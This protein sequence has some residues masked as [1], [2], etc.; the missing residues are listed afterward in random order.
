MNVGDVLYLQDKRTPERF[1]ILEILSMTDVDFVYDI[2]VRRSS[3]LDDVEFDCGSTSV[4]R[5]SLDR[6]NNGYA[7]IFI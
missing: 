1:F 6:W 3:P 4:S 7:I 2:M 5:D